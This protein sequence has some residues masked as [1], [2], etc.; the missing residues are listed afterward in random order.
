[1]G[2]EQ[3]CPCVGCRASTSTVRS[4]ALRDTHARIHASATPRAKR[5][6]GLCCSPRLSLVGK[7]SV[8][9]IGRISLRG[10]RLGENLSAI[11]YDVGENEEKAIKGADL[12]RWGVRVHVCKTNGGP[13]ESKVSPKDTGGASGIT[14]RGLGD[15]P[16]PRR[17]YEEYCIFMSAT[18]IFLAFGNRIIEIFVV[19]TVRFQKCT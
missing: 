12:S 13:K 10:N 1:M 2:V 18:I 14:K 17:K 7:F 11:S 9:L 15:S 8:N 16:R 19:C 4:I 6:P 5:S 3:T